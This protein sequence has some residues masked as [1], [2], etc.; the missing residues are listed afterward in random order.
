MRNVQAM[1]DSMSLE[2]VQVSTLVPWNLNPR[3]HGDDIDVLCKSIGSYGWTNPILAQR[4]TNRIMAGHGRFEAALRNNLLTVPVI[5]LDYD[6]NEAAAYTIADNALAENS[7]WNFDK[8]RTILDGFDIAGFDKGMT[9]LDSER[10]ANL[11]PSEE[12]AAGTE[13]DEEIAV[14]VELDVAFRV[15]IPVAS[16]EVFE[17]QLKE[18]LTKYPDATYKRSM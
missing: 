14:G 5:F 13:Y 12:D 7:S 17:L 16:A 10:M 1:I 9:F 2:K 8:L 11:F 6:D 15:K 18:L 4:G 3:E